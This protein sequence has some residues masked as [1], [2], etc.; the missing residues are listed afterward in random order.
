MSKSIAGA[1]YTG[2]F[3]DK[4]VASNKLSA[5]AEAI[6]EIVFDVAGAIKKIS[7]HKANST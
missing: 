2:H 7:A 1:K 6:L 3:E 5:L 4:Y